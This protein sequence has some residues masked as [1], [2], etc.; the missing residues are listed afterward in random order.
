MRS[1]EKI[2]LEKKYWDK[3]RICKLF[4]TMLYVIMHMCATVVIFVAHF[5]LFRFI[6]FF[7]V[8]WLAKNW[9]VFETRNKPMVSKV[10]IGRQAGGGD[11]GGGDGGGESLGNSQCSF[12]FK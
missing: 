10:E 11:G 6:F 5:F 9:N 8:K 1:S 12:L 2:T 7:A 3:V 4:Y